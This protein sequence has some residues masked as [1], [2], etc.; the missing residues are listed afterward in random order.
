MR[1][2][3]SGWTRRV[4]VYP[5][6]LCAREINM[7]RS[8]HFALGCWSA[9]KLSPI[10][11]AVRSYWEARGGGRGMLRS[12]CTVVSSEVRITDNT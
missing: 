7:E 3:P 12:I 9:R 1:M 10:S 8:E 4:K 6:F 5:V 11:K 2:K